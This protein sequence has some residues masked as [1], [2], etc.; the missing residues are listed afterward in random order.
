MFAIDQMIQGGKSAAEIHRALPLTSTFE[1]REDLPTLRTIQR[2]AQDRRPSDGQSRD[3]S[4]DSLFHLSRFQDYLDGDYGIPWEAAA[5]ILEMWAWVKE[6]GGEFGL[7]QLPEIARPT[8]RMAKWWW[9]VH[10]LAPGLDLPGVYINAEHF[11]MN[12]RAQD[13]FG[14]Q[15]DQAGLFWFLAYRP[16]ANQEAYIQYKSRVE[17]GLI[18]RKRVASLHIWQQRDEFAARVINLGAPTVTGDPWVDSIKVEIFEHHQYPRGAFE[19]GE[20]HDP[21]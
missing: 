18:P 12:E 2:I 10:L 6:C 20:A 9:R 17:E 15:V 16:W 7:D 3:C 13:L 11:T 4:P 5:Y 14:W 8:L 1:D 21:T 19:E